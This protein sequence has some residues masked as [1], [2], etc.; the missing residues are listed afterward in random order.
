MDFR[1]QYLQAMRDQ[2]PAL[3]KRLSRSGQLM[4]QASLKE[5]QA[6]KLFRELTDGLPRDKSGQLSLQAS[7][8]AEEQV[9]AAMFEFPDN[10]TSP[11][12]DEQDAL[13]GDRPILSS[14]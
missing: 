14:E 10:Q 7:R 11:E 2:A 13:R 8:E 5:R 9:K 12:Q 6:D 3:F 4:E 1:A